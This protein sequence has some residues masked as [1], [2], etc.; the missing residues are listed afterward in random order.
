MTESKVEAALRLRKEFDDATKEALELNGGP[1][2]RL[3][4]AV[5]AFLD[6][7][8]ALSDAE[9]RVYI[10]IYKQEKNA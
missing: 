2:E 9:F 6:A 7:E 3:N 10:T 4:A 1:T 5:K 8:N